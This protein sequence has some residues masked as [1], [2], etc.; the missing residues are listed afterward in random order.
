MLGNFDAL[1]LPKRPNRV[2]VVVNR[3]PDSVPTT[4]L[5]AGWCGPFRLMVVE[6]R[7]F[8]EVKQQAMIALAKEDLEPDFQIQC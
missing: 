8:S 7:T 3:N 2:P 1:T 4:F 6:A 5:A